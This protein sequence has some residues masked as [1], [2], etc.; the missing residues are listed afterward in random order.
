MNDPAKFGNES[1]F[2]KENTGIRTNIN[3]SKR[4]AVANIAT[5]ALL[6]VACMTAAY[7]FGTVIGAEQPD[8]TAADPASEEQAAQA[9]AYMLREDI[10][11]LQ[12]AEPVEDP[13]TSTFREQTC[14]I[15]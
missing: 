9:E 8:M 2:E 14:T 11:F 7:I 4:K 15:Q 10:G 12:E 3:K 6:I 5:I 1:E 13:D